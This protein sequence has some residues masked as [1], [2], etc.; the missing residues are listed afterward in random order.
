MEVKVISL[1]ELRINLCTTERSIRI[2]TII[3]MLT[4]LKQLET[5]KK[6]YENNGKT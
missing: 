2:N 3:S 6:K 4:E 5:L 1:K